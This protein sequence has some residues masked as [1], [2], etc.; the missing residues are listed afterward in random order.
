MKKRFNQKVAL[1]L[2]LMLVSCTAFASEI[3]MEEKPWYEIS[4]NLLILQ[5]PVVDSESCE[6]NYEISDPTILDLLS[7]EYE[8]TSEPE[9]TENSVT[10]NA[11]EAVSDADIADDVADDAPASIGQTCIAS[12][13]AIDGQTGEVTLTMTCSGEYENDPPVHTCI[14][15]LSIS[16]DGIEVI[17]AEQ[18]ASEAPEESV[19]ESESTGE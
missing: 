6:W 8:D 11:D 4:E 1:S 17:S 18:S 10:E 2:L 16:E 14:L 19:V 5:L 3:P 7:I 12:F 9:F 15:Q 13:E